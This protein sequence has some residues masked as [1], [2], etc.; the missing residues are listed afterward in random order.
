[1][2]HFSGYSGLSLEGVILCS[3]FLCKIIRKSEMKS[4]LISINREGNTAIHLYCFTSSDKKFL[5]PP[6]ILPFP[7]AT[8][9]NF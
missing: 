6:F 7:V 1:M 3:L 5:V 2:L 9:S 4:M 8:T